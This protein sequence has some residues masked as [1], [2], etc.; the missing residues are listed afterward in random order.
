MKEGVH[1]RHLADLLG[2]TKDDIEHGAVDRAVRRE[3]HDRSNELCRLASAPRNWRSAGRPAIL[4]DIRFSRIDYGRQFGDGFLQG[5]VR[6]D[7]V[8]PYLIGVGREIDLGI[9]IPIEN[10]G[11]LIVE[12]D[13]ILTLPFVLEEGLVGPHHFRI[14]FEPLA[15]A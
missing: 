1:A 4:R 9:S 6:V 14:F 10:A 5:R 8:L 3:H 15:R 7:R 2:L 13:E 11:F 12:I